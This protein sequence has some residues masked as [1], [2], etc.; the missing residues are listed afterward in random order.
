M[1]HILAG[2]HQESPSLSTYFEE[3]SFLYFFILYFTMGRQTK[4][5]LVEFMEPMESEPG[6]ACEKAEKVRLM[7]LIKRLKYGECVL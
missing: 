6:I 7:K 3:Y 5:K 2:G 1:L 4:F